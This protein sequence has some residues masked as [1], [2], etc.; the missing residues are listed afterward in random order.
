MIFFPIYLASLLWLANDIMGTFQIICEY[1]VPL[2]L[3][4][5]L[6]SRLLRLQLVLCIQ[7]P[8]CW[9]TDVTVGSRGARFSKSMRS[10]VQGQLCFKGR[11]S[12]GL[13][14]RRPVSGLLLAAHPVCDSGEGIS[15]PTCV[16]WGNIT[17]QWF[18]S[19][20]SSE[21]KVSASIWSVS[22]LYDFMECFCIKL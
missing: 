2:L 10:F 21:L 22:L 13:G 19:C 9:G 6:P 4:L 3:L 1:E 15:G 11:T 17:N 14:F 18:S 5:L 12:A 20:F 8:C 16:K 7:R